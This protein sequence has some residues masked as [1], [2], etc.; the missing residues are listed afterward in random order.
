MPHALRSFLKLK[1]MTWWPLFR[2]PF[3]IDAHPEGEEDDG[4]WV[5]ESMPIRSNRDSSGLSEQKAMEAS[6][7]INV[8]V[9]NQG[10]AHG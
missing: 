10:V 9:I 1:S 8:G 2:N 7:A 6:D 5:S 4:T 3:T